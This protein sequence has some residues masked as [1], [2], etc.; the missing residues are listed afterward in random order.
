MRRSSELN[1]PEFPEVT[2]EELWFFRGGLR[3]GSTPLSNNSVVDPFAGVL[4]SFPFLR[5]MVA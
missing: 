5:R 2:D 3:G 4:F 1:W